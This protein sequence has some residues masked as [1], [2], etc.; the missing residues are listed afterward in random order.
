MEPE[1]KR[2]WKKQSGAGLLM[3]EG[4]RLALPGTVRDSQSQ[5]SLTDYSLH[6]KDGKRQR[7]TV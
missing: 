7:K 3:V 6:T 1:G 4:A 2:L 5:H